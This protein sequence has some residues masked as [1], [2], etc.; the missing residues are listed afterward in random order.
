MARWRCCGLFVLLWAL[1]LGGCSG[2]GEGDTAATR[3]GKGAVFPELVMRDLSGG[4]GNSKELFRN[5][6]VVLN[7]W[8][9]WCPPC[10]K[11]MPDLIALS[12][13]LPAKDFLVIGLSVDEDLRVLQEYIDANGVSFPIYWDQGGRAIA[14]D[15]LGV[16]KYPET[17]ILNR[18]GVLVERV[19]GAYPWNAEETVNTL[20]YIAEHGKLPSS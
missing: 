7:V 1:F 5:K 14:A 10:R 16:F 4:V 8:A 13:R 17:F 6:V 12:R 11:E 18:D 9:T 3:L 2:S 19:I 20:H 15:R